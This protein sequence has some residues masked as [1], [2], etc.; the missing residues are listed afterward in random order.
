MIFDNKFKTVHSLPD[1]KEL[2]K[3]WTM[4]VRLGH[5]CFLDVDFDNNGNPIVSTMSEL[6]K[7]YSKE[8]QKRLI[9][10]DITAIGREECSTNNQIYDHNESQAESPP[11][12]Q[13]EIPPPLAK[14]TQVPGG[15][16][17]IQQDA[18][19]DEVL[20]GDL[21][22]Q[23]STQPRRNVGTYKDGPAKICRLP[24]DCKEYKLAFNVDVINDWEKPMQAIS[25]TRC[26]TKDFHPN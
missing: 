8:K 22:Q 6:I 17:P 18:D 11:P 15:D 20:E 16:F 7:A 13:S 12:L 21:Q 23:V 14:D 24:I 25:N 10:E 5:K 19:L 4:I 9:G 2:E 3:Q 1:N 26:I